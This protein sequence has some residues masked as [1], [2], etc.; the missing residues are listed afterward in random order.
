[1][2]LG[3]DLDQV[4]LETFEITLEAFVGIDDI[5]LLLGQGLSLLEVEAVLLHE[6]G[7]HK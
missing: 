3:V 5:P 7:D 6:E 2:D 4:V 1:M